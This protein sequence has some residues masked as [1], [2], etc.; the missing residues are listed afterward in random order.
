MTGRIS[1]HGEL[2]FDVLRYAT[3]LLAEGDESTLM[4]MGFTAEQIRSIETLTLKS[5]QRV[6]ALSSHF[7]DFRVD[8]TCFARVMRRIEQEREDEAL[9]DELLRAGA[10]IRMMHHFWG[11]TSRDCA[12]RRR[13]LDIEPPIGRPA[14]ADDGALERLWHLWQDTNAMGDERRRYLELAQRS[15]LP[16]SVIWIAVEEWKGESSAA[17]LP[18]SARAGAS[19]PMS[20]STAR[21]VVELHR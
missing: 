19:A 5:L 14:L 2:I 12:E 17:E 16:L 7:L 1:E 11:M 15:E 10:P 8:A 21:R 18:S 13:V 20:G 4:V 6:G 9:K 3:R